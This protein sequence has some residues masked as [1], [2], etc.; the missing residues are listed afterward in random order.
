VSREDQKSGKKETRGEGLAVGAPKE[1]CGESASCDLF[2]GW[3]QS[4]VDEK[5][6]GADAREDPGERK[7]EQSS[8]VMSAAATRAVTGSP[9]VDRHNGGEAPSDVGGAEAD[10][11]RD[12]VETRASE[13]QGADGPS[14]G[15]ARKPSESSSESSKNNGELFYETFRVFSSETRDDDVR[16]K[17]GNDEP[18]G[19]DDDAAKGSLGEGVERDAGRDAERDESTADE[20]QETDDAQ[21][22]AK[23]SADVEGALVMCFSHSQTFS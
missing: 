22:E 13:V 1:A 6:D 17:E 5:R 20:R 12:A 19:G 9:T 11:K 21:V 7:G 10:K 16:D 2:E 3:D 23:K 14:S 18:A 4:D 15:D 8:E